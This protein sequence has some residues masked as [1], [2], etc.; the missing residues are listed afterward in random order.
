MLTIWGRTNSINVQKPLMALEELGVPYTRIDAGLHFGV[1]TTPEFRAMNP[2]AVVPV[3]DDVGFIM[4]ESN[5]IVRYLARK[6]GDGRL[7]P[8]DIRE[9]ANQDRWMDWQHTSIVGPINACFAPLIRKV[10]DQRPE[11]IE[12]GR[13]KAE[14]K[15]AM[16]DDWLAGK[17]WI[18]GDLFGC[19]ECVLG[20]S[21]HR[22]YHLPVERQSHAHVERWLAALMAR[23]SAKKI[24]IE[25]I[26]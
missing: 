5:S 13:A 8:A 3:I 22:W 18:G 16:L 26:T 1:N 12:A 7:W 14:E 4:W 21:V 10:G 2:N 6:Y 20:P 23:P 9:Q 15:L 19:A 25:P 17:Q 11:A 24:I